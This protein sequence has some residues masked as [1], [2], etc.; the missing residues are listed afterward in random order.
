MFKNNIKTRNIKK[1]N[2]KYS[3]LKLLIQMLTKLLCWIKLAD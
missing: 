2:Y 1:S 3:P